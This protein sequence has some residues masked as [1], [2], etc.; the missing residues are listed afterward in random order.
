MIVNDGIML[1]MVKTNI[2]TWATNSLL[3]VHSV[4]WP[5]QKHI[6]QSA[7]DFAKE[8]NCSSMQISSLDFTTTI[9]SGTANVEP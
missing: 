5:K 1:I 8:L 6:S 3:L 2:G 7:G 9:Q 4:V